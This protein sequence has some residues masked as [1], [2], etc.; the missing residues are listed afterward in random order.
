[1]LLLLATT[2]HFPNPCAHV[3]LCLLLEVLKGFVGI[4]LLGIEENPTFIE[5]PFLGRSCVL[6]MMMIK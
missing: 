6:D 1:M 3:T 2:P 5:Y 4:I